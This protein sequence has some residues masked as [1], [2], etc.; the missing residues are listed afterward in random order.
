MIP[1]GVK[2]HRLKT[3]ALGNIIG[4][5]SNAVQWKSTCVIFAGPWISDVEKEEEKGGRQVNR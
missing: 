4:M 5:A 3:T 2:T 1:Q